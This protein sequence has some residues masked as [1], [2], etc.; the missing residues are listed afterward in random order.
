MSLNRNLGFEIVTDSEIREDAFLFG[1]GQGRVVVTVS[2]DEED[3]FLEYMIASKVN[4]T[5]LG[6]VTKGKMVID[7]DHYGFVKEAKE[8]Y[9]NAL[10]KILEN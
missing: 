4:L 2:E 1:E 8:V 6:H 5:L 3:E 10:G 7:D 9:E